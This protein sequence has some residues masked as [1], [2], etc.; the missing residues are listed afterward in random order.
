MGLPELF[1]TLSTNQFF[2]AGFGLMGVG[3]GVA[4]AR[5][6]FVGYFLSYTFALYRLLYVG[7][8]LFYVVCSLD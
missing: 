6:W 3:M 8:D 2:S 1:A 7:P 5:K 4:A